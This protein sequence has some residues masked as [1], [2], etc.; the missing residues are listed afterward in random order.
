MIIKSLAINSGLTIFNRSL[1]GPFISRGRGTC[2]LQ[3][4]DN[5]PDNGINDGTVPDD[6]W[7]GGIH[8]GGER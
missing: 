1:Y 4:P 2:P 5:N 6:V 7:V 8:A 3:E